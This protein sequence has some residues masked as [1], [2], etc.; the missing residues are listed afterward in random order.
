MPAATASSAATTPVDVS[1]SGS[2]RYENSPTAPNA[3][4]PTTPTTRPAH[5]TPAER[6]RR[7]AS[8]DDDDAD[9]QRDLVV[10]AE[11]R[12]GEVLERRGEAVDELRADGRD[13]RRPRAADPHDQLAGGERDTGGDDAGDGAPST[14]RTRVRGYGGAAARARI[15]SVATAMARRYAHRATVGTRSA[16]R[17]RNS[18]RAGTACAAVRRT[19]AL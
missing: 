14:P 13:Q 6:P 5:A 18:R 12:D 15:D 2:S 9:D 16:K 7:A 17:T 1:P 19:V 10:G 3:T 11:Q 4:K 8:D